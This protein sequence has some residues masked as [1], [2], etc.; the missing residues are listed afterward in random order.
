M[1]KVAKGKEITW[2][3]NGRWG[4]RKR[5]GV[6]KAFIPRGANARD[7][8][9]KRANKSSLIGSEVNSFN[10]RYLMA[11]PD[12]KGG[13]QFQTPR[14][15]VIETAATKTAAPRTTKKK[16]AKKAT[17]KKATRKRAA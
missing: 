12:G 14:S 2:H 10:D 3:T 16:V 1:K 4:K 13:T 17:K 8:M 11:V 9:P 7:Y 15:G 5:N 6:V